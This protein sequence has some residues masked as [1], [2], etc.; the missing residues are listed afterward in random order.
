MST[1]WHV[2]GVSIDHRFRGRVIQLL[3]VNH[4]DEAP[5]DLIVMESEICTLGHIQR[6]CSR[7]DVGRVQVWVRSLARAVWACRE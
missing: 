5:A 4:D 7:R 3:R 1:R 6:S 2:S